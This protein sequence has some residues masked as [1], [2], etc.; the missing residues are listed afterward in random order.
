MKSGSLI[1]KAFCLCVN[2]IQK[3]VRK[4]VVFAN[5]YEQDLAAEIPKFP[6]KIS[7]H[8]QIIESLEDLEAHKD[9]FS[10]DK[11]AENRDRI[12]LHQDK[13][14]AFFHGE[15]LAGW[16][17]FTVARRSYF[18]P[19]HMHNIAIP[20]DASFLYDGNTLPGFQRKG[21]Y[22]AKFSAIPDLLKSYGKKRF[23]YMLFS[24]NEAGVKNAKKFR[25]KQTKKFC[26]LNLGI[27]RLVIKIKG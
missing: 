4:F 17:F 11:Y 26:Y 13:M 8:V 21:V 2:R 23:F 3:S 10:P 20:E 1:K 24:H 27:F 12:S 18:E 16:S 14:V 22:A 15:K 19:T 7:G 25:F 5:M 6:A 9:S